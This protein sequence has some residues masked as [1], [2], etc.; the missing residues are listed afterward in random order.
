MIQLIFGTLLGATGM[1]ILFNQNTSMGGTDITAKIL[2]K[3]MNI[4][5]GKGVP[6][7]DFS[8]VLAAA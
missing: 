1:A 3:Y 2:N 7:C 8:Y 4:D 5:Q 6:L